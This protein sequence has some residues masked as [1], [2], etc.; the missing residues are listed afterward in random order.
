[1]IKPKRS[2]LILSIALFAL[3][4]AFTVLV[5]TADKAAGTVPGT[6]I[7]LSHLNLA[8]FNATHKNGEI[9]QGWY[10]L[11]QFLG[12]LA[13][14]EAAGFAVYGVAQLIRRKSLKKIDK[15]LF[16]HAVSIDSADFSESLSCICLSCVT[17]DAEE[18]CF[19]HMDTSCGTMP[20]R[21]IYNYM[22]RWA[23]CYRQ[24]KTPYP[25]KARIAAL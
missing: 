3:F 8:F 4:F 6:E 19:F 7:G 17:A 5:A 13:L 21:V 18:N 10:K 22:Y 11:T 12:Y 2:V 15:D 20:D 24:N 16:V 14:M 1:M 25:C 23:E 9:S